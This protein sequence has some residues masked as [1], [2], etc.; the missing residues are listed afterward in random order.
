MGRWHVILVRGLCPSTS[1]GRTPPNT[2][3]WSA[4]AALDYDQQLNDD[5]RLFGRLQLRYKGEASTN[6][7]FFDITRG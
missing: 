5:M 3:D 7:Q 1:S 2:V 6:A 4:T